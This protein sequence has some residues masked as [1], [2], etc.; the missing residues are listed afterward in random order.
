MAIKLCDETYKNALLSVVIT[1]LIN[2]AIWNAEYPPNTDETVGFALASIAFQKFV[3]D[4]SSDVIIATLNCDITFIQQIIRLP[5]VK[6][7]VIRNAFL[8]FSESFS[9]K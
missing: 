1:E 2:S 7:L 5:L 4:N 6:L 8:N 9:V 3:Q